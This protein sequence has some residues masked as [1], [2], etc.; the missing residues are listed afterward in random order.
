MPSDPLNLFLIAHNSF[1]A[2]SLFLDSALLVTFITKEACLVVWSPVFFSLTSHYVVGIS[3]LSAMENDNQSMV[4]NKA[5]LWFQSGTSLHEGNHTV[6]R[7]VIKLPWSLP[8]VFYVELSAC[9]RI[10]LLKNIKRGG[11][12]TSLSGVWTNIQN[13]KVADHYGRVTLRWNEYISWVHR[14][15]FFD[16]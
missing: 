10:C 4:T 6:S 1:V 16:L 3:F 13:L 12:F 8:G 9:K 7:V 2:T 11:T 14:F 5:I 15:Y